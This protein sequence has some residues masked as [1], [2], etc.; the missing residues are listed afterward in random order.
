MTGLKKLFF[1]L[2]IKEEGVFHILFYV[3]SIYKITQRKHNKRV[4]IV[5]HYSGVNVNFQKRLVH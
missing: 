2:L 3:L 5:Y 1:L 4:H